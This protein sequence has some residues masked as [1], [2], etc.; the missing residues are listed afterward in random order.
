MMATIPQ[1]VAEVASIAATLE[2]DPLFYMGRSVSDSIIAM[3]QAAEAFQT[4]TD[5]AGRLDAALWVGEAYLLFSNGLPDSG[6]SEHSTGW[7]TASQI[8]KLLG[9]PAIWEARCR[10]EYRA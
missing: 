10:E 1:V 7:A 8:S 6:S 4:A 3:Q 9:G 5:D 2:D